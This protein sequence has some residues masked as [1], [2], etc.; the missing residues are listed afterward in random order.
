MSGENT[1][2]SVQGSSALSSKGAWDIARPF[3]DHLSKEI[4]PKLRETV[5]HI[6]QALK[7][8]EAR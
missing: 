1:W 2:S 3:I 4:L 5:V 8:Q 7:R 6:S